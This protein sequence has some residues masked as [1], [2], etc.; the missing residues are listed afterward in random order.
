MTRLASWLRR[1]ADRLDPPGDGPRRLLFWGP[2]DGYLHDLE[3]VP[4]AIAFDPPELPRLSMDDG[5]DWEDWRG[6]VY[7]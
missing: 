4:P 7:L 6:G 3:A 5:D 1:F 2:A